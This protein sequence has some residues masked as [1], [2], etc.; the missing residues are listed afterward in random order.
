MVKHIAAMTSRFTGAEGRPSLVLALRSQRL[1]QN[2]ASVANALVDGG[3]LL[4]FRN[5]D[6]LIE[7][8]NADNAV[9]LIISG[10]VDVFVNKRHVATR[11]PREC[12]GEMSV[13]DPTAPRAA[14]VI[15]KS[16]VVALR[17]GEA[18]FVSIAEAAPRI[19]RAA[20]Q[21]L[22]E[23][24]RER[25]KFHRPANK[26]PIMFVG[27][28]VEG[29]PIA[30][31]LERELKHVDV[32]VRVWSRGVFGPSGVPIDDLLAQVQEADFAVFVFGPDDRVASRNEEHRAPR[33]NVVFEMGLFMGR[34]GRERVFMLQEQ[35]SDLK[36]PSDL[37]GITPLTYLCRDGK[38]C[39]LGPPSTDLK[40]AIGK[41]GVV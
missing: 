28:S 24:L 15:A 3:E 37:L 31:L 19:W 39:E 40:E 32:V 10:N 26:L 23:R 29:L 9:F 21:V 41:L 8:G 18:A 30:Q 25:E 36:I 16:D 35:H 12:I 33:D 1:I 20:A 4:H 34:L 38:K 17:V 6:A 14:T 11:G 27:S 7:Q 22:A 5:G 13:I 2:D